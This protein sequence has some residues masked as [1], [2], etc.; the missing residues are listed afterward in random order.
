MCCKIV[1]SE[2]KQGKYFA[3]VFTAVGLV[4]R[5]INFGPGVKIKL[6]NNNEVCLFYFVI[7]I[8]AQLSLVIT[9]VF[10]FFHVR[11]AEEP[12]SKKQTLDFSLC[13]KCQKPG[14]LVEQHLG[15]PTYERV[16]DSVRKR[17][18]YGNPDFVQ[19][20][21]RLH[22]LSAKDLEENHAS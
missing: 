18:E 17:S 12:P 15:L 13:L 22:G 11:M 5:F 8:I 1:F 7:V 2:S 10:H 20:N 16:L 3:T 21:K 9:V 4:I 14:P 6:S 19:L